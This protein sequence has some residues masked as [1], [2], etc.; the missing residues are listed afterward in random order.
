MLCHWQLPYI[1]HLISVF[2]EVESKSII[3]SLS[4]PFPLPSSSFSSIPPLH[5]H[6]PELFSYIAIASDQAVNNVHQIC[7]LLEDTF[8]CCKLVYQALL[9]V[10]QAEEHDPS[11][12]VMIDVINKP[13]PNREQ[14]HSFSCLKPLEAILGQ[15]KP[16]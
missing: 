16:L 7:K 14:S 4:S 2:G 5:V 1:P 10:L 8:R 13:Q 12:G 6:S 3:I 15:A 9:S 11:V